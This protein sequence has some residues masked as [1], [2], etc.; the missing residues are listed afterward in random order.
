MPKWNII[1]FPYKLIIYIYYNKP[2][3]AH[4]PDDTYLLD[5]F[6]QDYNAILLLQQLSSC[7]FQLVNS[8]LSSPI[9][10]IKEK[11][12]NY[13]CHLL[14]EIK[15]SPQS[16]NVHWNNT[17]IVTTQHRNLGQSLSSLLHD[18]NQKIFYLLIEW[19]YGC[20]TPRSIYT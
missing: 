13:A 15:Y 4:W 2:E 5:Q 1:K 10:D 8:Y 16:Y 12:S 14:F 6:Q 18:F 3:A 7:D 11:V 17:K 9:C 20:K 19:A